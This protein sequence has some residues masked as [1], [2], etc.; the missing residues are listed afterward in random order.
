[1]PLFHH[2]LETAAP[3]D[4]PAPVLAELRGRMVANAHRNF[5]LTR[6]LLAV[7]AALRARE[8]PAL[9]YKGPALAAMAYGSVAARQFVD[10]D[11]LVPRE[12]IADARA[13]LLARGYRDALAGMDSRIPITERSHYQ[14]TMVRDTDRVC[15]EL[16]WAFAPPYFR[17]RLGPDDL[18]VE[19]SPLGRATI[20][21]IAPPDLLLLL[22]IHGGRHLWTRLGWICDL[23]ELLRARADAP[24][25]VALDRATE[26]GTRR[27]LLVGLALARDLLDIDLPEVFAAALPGDPRAVQL[28]EVFATRLFLQDGRAPALLGAARLHVA[29]RE[30]WADRAAYAVLGAL[31]PSERD[32]HGSGP[33]RA[34][35]RPFRLI[36]DFGLWNGRR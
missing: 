32:T 12:R 4:A 25:H 11:I 27:M 20:P 24:W 1:M 30:R 16:H 5:A 26:L 19:P 2:Q 22:C 3:D 15:V 6:E 9:P 13:A 18:T 7:L 10:L 14:H 21:A 35:A 31:T 28:A 36:R 8:I 34:V 33:L 29:M 17:F 23:A